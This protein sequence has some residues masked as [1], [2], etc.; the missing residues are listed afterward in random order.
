MRF[1]NPAIWGCTRGIW[2]VRL[3]SPSFLLLRTAKAVSSSLVLMEH[4]HAISGQSNGRKQLLF[5]HV[6]LP[7]DG[8]DNEWG[9]LQENQVI[10]AP[11]IYALSHGIIIGE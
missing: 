10:M 7:L 8:V 1:Q 9:V 2:N 5:E 11:S 3:R 4:A 6:V